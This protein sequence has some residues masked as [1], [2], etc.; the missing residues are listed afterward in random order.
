M[1]ASISAKIPEQL[2][3][4]V[5]EI[6]RIEHRSASNVVRLAIEHYVSQYTELHPQFRADILEGLK[7][8][9]KGK[10]EPYEFG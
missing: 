2:R 6:A 10:V 8:V 3:E 1:T 5:E 9:R 4:R 7:T